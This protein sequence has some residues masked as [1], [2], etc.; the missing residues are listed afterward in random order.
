MKENK[1]DNIGQLGEEKIPALLLKFSLPVVIAL[2]V[3]ALYNFVDRI[4]IGNGVGSLGIAGITIVYPIMLVMGACAT[5]V[6]T[7]A[8]SL[9]S[10]RLGEKKANVAERVLGNAIVLLIMLSIIITI[11][12]LLFI[13]PI[14]RSF[15][16]SSEVLPYAKDYMGI[17]MLGTIFQ[18]LGLGMNYSIRADGSP[19]KAMVT[20]LI[21]AILNTILTP[22]FI[23]GFNLGMKGA[24]LATIISQAVSAAWVMYY[25]IG[26]SSFLKIHIQN[27]KLISDIV[28]PILAIG[29]ASFMMQLTL[30][31]SNMIMNKSLVHYGGDIAVSAMGVI[32]SII[33]LI[34][35][36]ILGISQGIQPI[37]G[38]NYGAQKFDRV[39]EALQSGVI[40]ATVIATLG[41][42]IIRV[43]PEQL[44]SLFNSQNKE[45]I[46][47]GSYAMG[48]SMI[49]VPII[50]IQMI[51]TGYF[52]AIGK[53][54]QAMFLTLLRQVI[55][56]IP[57]LLI[58]PQYF[59]LM[60]I[61]IS[62]PL[63]DFLSF[64]ITGIWL[65]A[66]LKTLN[67]KQLTY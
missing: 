6:G 14:L 66:E 25:F 49:F 16:A 18:V 48:I 20:M 51:V 44:M 10:I 42:I 31:L 11:S 60:G 23:F 41:F 46:S 67:K 53:P 7:G 39:K 43:F 57:A 1:E 35:L 36:P 19:Q 21:G 59:Q 55:F 33:F 22:I 62:I 3:N 65:S 37:I 61:L 9:I 50:G 30:S 29:A 32:F 34:V 27:L 38:F 56:L 45:F 47:I 15:G 13:N 26:G 5:L 2:L 12:G 64:I 52:Q 54:K 8:A 24:A 28:K 58:L 17:I 40:A 4:F 63:S